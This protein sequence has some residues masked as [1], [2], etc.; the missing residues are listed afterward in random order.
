MKWLR[1]NH[2]QRDGFCAG[3]PRRLVR[4]H[5]R[6]A[7]QRGGQAELRD[8]EVPRLQCNGRVRGEGAKDGQAQQHSLAHHGKAAGQRGRDHRTPGN[9]GLQR[10]WGRL[11]RGWQKAV[12]PAGVYCF[13]AGRIDR[14]GPTESRLCGGGNY[15]TLD[16]P[17][18]APETA[19]GATAPAVA[20]HVVQGSAVRGGL[21][22]TFTP[23][24]PILPG[25]AGGRS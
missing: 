17:V 13:R 1:S 22:Q 10:R 4:V 19:D 8:P 24:P 21:A 14:E 7:L 9:H 12:Q 18:H 2:R 20:P 16:R 6:A 25:L 23:P 11:H 5:F 15:M 3:F